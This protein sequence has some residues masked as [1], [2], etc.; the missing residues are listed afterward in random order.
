MAQLGLRQSQILMIGHSWPTNGLSPADPAIEA[1]RTWPGVWALL[2][3]VFRA[4][5]ESFPH[6]PAITEGRARVLWCGAEPGR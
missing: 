6:D 4:G 5:G 2:E 3:P 1:G